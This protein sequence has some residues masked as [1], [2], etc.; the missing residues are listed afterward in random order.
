VQPTIAQEYRHLARSAPS[1]EPHAYAR[2]RRAIQASIQS[3]TLAPGH[4]LPSERELCRHRMDAPRVGEY[5][6]RL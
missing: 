5:L 4:A 3:G 6:S 2:L 1:S